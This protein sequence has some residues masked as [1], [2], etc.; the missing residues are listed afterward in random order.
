MFLLRHEKYERSHIAPSAPLSKYGT[1]NKR[2]A[3]LHQQR[4]V[5]PEEGDAGRSRN[6]R[7]VECDASK[8]VLWLHTLVLGLISKNEFAT[9]G[10]L[11][12]P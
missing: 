7:R 12:S 5:I 10:V 9:T 8:T 6:A 1:R 2:L 11:I 4:K 3:F